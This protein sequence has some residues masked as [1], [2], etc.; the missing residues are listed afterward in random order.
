MSI[1]KRYK[2]VMGLTLYGNVEVFRTQK[3][4]IFFITAGWM[5]VSVIWETF[6]KLPW[7]QELCSSYFDDSVT[8]QWINH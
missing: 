2:M 8:C 7:I 4:V 1:C 6:P 3:C 5:N